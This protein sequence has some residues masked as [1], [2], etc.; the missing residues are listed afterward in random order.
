[1]R[2]L[3]LIS[4]LVTVVASCKDS[5][6]KFTFDSGPSPVTDGALADVRKVDAGGDTSG[7]ADAPKIDAAGDI[8]ATDASKVDAGADTFAAADGSSVADV[9]ADQSVLEAGADL[10]SADVPADLAVTT[11]GANDGDATGDAE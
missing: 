6:T 3:V 9:G 11:D 5:G 2:S 1:M 10:P 8:S 4:L 7:A